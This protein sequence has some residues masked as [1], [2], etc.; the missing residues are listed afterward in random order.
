LSIKGTSGLPPPEMLERRYVT[1]TVSLLRKTQSN[2]QTKLSMKYIK[3]IQISSLNTG[4]NSIKWYE[5][6]YFKS[7]SSHGVPKTLE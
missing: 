1:N 2:K 7:C 5:N 3:D 6:K 4:F